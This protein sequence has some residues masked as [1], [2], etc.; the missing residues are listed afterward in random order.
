M[1]SGWNNRA[2]VT[3]MMTML[4]AGATLGQGESHS[5]WNFSNRLQLGWEIDSNVQ[6]ALRHAEQ[7]RSLRLIFDSRSHRYG[8]IVSLHFSYHSGLQT[9]W[10]Y[11]RENKLINEASGKVTFRLNKRLETGVQVW[12][13]LKLF[14][15][16]DTDYALGQLSPFLQAKLPGQLF[17][18]SG[19]RVE[20]LDYA[21]SDYYDYSSPAFYCQLG[22]PIVQDLTVS[23]EF[24]FGKVQLDR[25]AYRLTAGPQNWLPT[26]GRQSDKMYIYSIRVDWLWHGLLIN[27]SYSFE[28]YRS[29]SYGFNFNRHQMTLMFARKLTSILVRG[30]GT[31][32][33]KSYLDAF[34]PF[35]LLELD[36]EKEES[37]FAVLDLSRD[38]SS[39]LTLNLRAAWYKNE[40]PWAS[41]YYQKRM[42]NLGMEIRF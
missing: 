38:L 8:K 1:R 33:K 27:S 18:Q 11:A 5:A 26:T 12:G 39:S 31:I 17:L 23:P 29:N 13:R 30:Y 32:Q 25:P 24:S 2:L 20:N 34:L 7:A 35:W 9:Y 28:S 15:S 16:Q 14:L 21:E 42:I 6:E 19:W 37:N 3:A 4:W 10:K 22:I 40:S 36:S 41:L